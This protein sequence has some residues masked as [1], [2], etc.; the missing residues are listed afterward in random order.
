MHIAVARYFIAV[1]WRKFHGKSWWH[2]T[3]TQLFPIVYLNKIVECILDKYAPLLSCWGTNKWVFQMNTVCC[4]TNWI[5]S[6]QLSIHFYWKRACHC[7]RYLKM[8]I[9]RRRS[10][11][12]CRHRRSSSAYRTLS[13]LCLLRDPFHTAFL[14]HRDHLVFQDRKQMNANNLPILWRLISREQTRCVSVP[15]AQV[16][17]LK[18]KS[19]RSWFWSHSSSGLSQWEKIRWLLC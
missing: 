8:R 12:N 7:T 14:S 13:H 16:H 17:W 2:R 3:C 9:F 19:D 18:H 5:A 15:E 10:L 11:C 1:K 4:C 6:D